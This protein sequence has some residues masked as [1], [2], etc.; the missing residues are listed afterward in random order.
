MNGYLSTSCVQYNSGMNALEP[1]H[2]NGWRKYRGNKRER[3]GFQYFFLFRLFEISFFSLFFLQW[4]FAS[5]IWW[6]MVG[7]KISLSVERSASKNEI[8]GVL[9]WVISCI[10]W[11]FKTCY[12]GNW[13]PPPMPKL[14]LGLLDHTHLGVSFHP[15]RRSP[16][17]RS[18]WSVTCTSPTTY[19]MLSKSFV[20]IVADMDGGAGFQCHLQQFS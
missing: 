16:L 18:C 9:C 2:K 1:L 14:L 17:P 4:F 10:G 3:R 20:Q 7:D 12:L 19:P 8:S 13:D 11:I 5:I 15:R 6:L